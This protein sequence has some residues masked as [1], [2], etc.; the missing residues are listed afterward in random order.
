MYLKLRKKKQ[1]TDFL[2]KCGVPGPLLIVETVTATGLCA[3]SADITSV[4]LLR[5]DDCPRR[6][7]PD[8]LSFKSLL[9]DR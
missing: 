7:I 2:T 6:N 3:A 4:L 8:N 5:D 1:L 9:L